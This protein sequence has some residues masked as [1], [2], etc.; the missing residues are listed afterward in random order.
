VLPSRELARGPEAT[1]L[2]EHA[3]R[4]Q[5]VLHASSMWTL[6][7]AVAAGV[8]LCVLPTN[9]AHMHADIELLRPLPEIAPRPVWLA[10]HPDQRRV[11]RVRAVADAVG[12]ALAERLARGADGRP[13]P[14][15]AVRRGG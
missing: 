4:A 1:W 5:P 12:G 11:A 3:S 15:A 2:A 9:L 6:A 13:A 14:A 7:V 8:G 10:M